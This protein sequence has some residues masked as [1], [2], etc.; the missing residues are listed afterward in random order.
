MKWTKEACRELA[1]KCRTRT[2][3][4][5]ISNSAYKRAIKYGWLDDILPPMKKS[6]WGKWQSKDN[7]RKVARKC[8]SKSEMQKRFSKAY[9]N[10]VGNNWIDEFFPKAKTHRGK[11]F[12]NKENCRKEAEKYDNITD[13]SKKSSRAYRVSL[14]NGWLDEF[15][16]KNRRP[17]PYVRKEW[18]KDEC[19]E[20]ASKC[21]GSRLAFC[22]LKASAFR[23]AQ[24]KGWLDELFGPRNVETKERY[25]KQA[26][27]YRK[28]SDFKKSARESYKYCLMQ[29]WIE[30]FYPGEVR[31]KSTGRT[32]RKLILDYVANNGPQTKEQL[33]KVMLTV[34][35]QK[36]DR[37]A[38][39][40]SWLDNV[41]F[42]TSVFIP[43]R[44]DMRYLK[45]VRVFKGEEKKYD[46]VTVANYEI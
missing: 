33:Y 42:G 29:G 12:W 25:R 32:V 30:E 20:L 8:K 44:V 15:G 3:M 24:S 38:W 2:E 4:K 5:R 14:D 16:F 1:S 17:V 36:L 35:G 19:R 39:G 43:S 41:S 40:V 27:Q 9:M 46:I 21:G 31:M 34:S 28:S 6:G 37:K 18:T 45:P 10:S 22:K 13:F 26:S 11:V 23:Y 7:C